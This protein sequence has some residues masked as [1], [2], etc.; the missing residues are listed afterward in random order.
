[1]WNGI[2]MKCEMQNTYSCEMSKLK[3]SFVCDLLCRTELMWHV[4]SVKWMFMWNVKCFYHSRELESEIGS[5]KNPVILQLQCVA[6]C[7]RDLVQRQWDHM[8]SGA[9]KPLSLCGGGGGGWMTIND[10]DPGLG[11]ILFLTLSWN[12]WMVW[13]TIHK[14]EPSFSDKAGSENRSIQCPVFELPR[15]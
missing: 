12:E 5:H 13:R 1:M 14:H 15:Q 6:T 9:T 10:Q 4:G 7:Q 2:H 11:T 8:P 3:T